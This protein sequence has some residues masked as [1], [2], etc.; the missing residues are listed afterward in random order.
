MFNFICLQAPYFE[1]PVSPCDVRFVCDS[2]VHRLGKLLR[3]CGIDT[4]LSSDEGC[5]HAAL[6]ENRLILSRGSVAQKVASAFDLVHVKDC[7]KRD[8]SELDLAI[9]VHP[10][11][12]W[13]LY[14]WVNTL[15]L[16]GVWAL[17]VT[18]RKPK[19]YKLFGFITFGSKR[20]ISLLDARY[21]ISRILYNK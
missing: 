7:E 17:K 14:S 3:S 18:Y 10:F 12:V 1:T 16:V 21:L 2:M 19:F 15:L 13:C 11:L 5:V 8:I 4:T 9:K 6:R 20:N